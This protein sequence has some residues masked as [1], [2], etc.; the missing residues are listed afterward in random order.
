MYHNGMFN[1]DLWDDHADYI[2]F[3]DMNEKNFA[4]GYKQWFGGQKV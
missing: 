4:I 1:L 3:D 2:I